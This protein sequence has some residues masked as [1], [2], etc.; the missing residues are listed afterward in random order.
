[1]KKK[2]AV[3][4]GGWGGEYLKEV[5][6]GIKKAARDENTD[7]FLFVNFSSHTDNPSLNAGEFNIFTLPDLRD[8]DGMILMPNSFNMQEELDYFAGQLN[9]GC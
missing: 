4:A 3:F 8:F 1:M 9:S 6:Y 5:M 7:V 2:I